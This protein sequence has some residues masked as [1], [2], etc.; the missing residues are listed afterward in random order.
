MKQ[1]LLP[2]AL[3]ACAACAST[4]EA[5]EPQALES[6]RSEVVQEPEPIG[7]L[8]ADLNAAQRAWTRLAMAA[9]TEEERREARLLEIDLMRRTQERLDEL[10]AELEGGPP[11]NRVIAASAVGFTRAPRAQPPLLAALE[12]P[13]PAVRSNAL[14][15]LTLLG[16]EDTPL[17]PICRLLRS[18]ED[19]WLRSNAALCL[20]TLVA[21]GAREDCA[22][23]AAR[24]GLLDPEP[25]VRAQSA[26]C[27]ATLLD[28]SSTRAIVDLL[29]DSVPLVQHA[30][31]R[32]LAHLGRE[33]ASERPL[34][35]KALVASYQDARGSARERLLTELQEL[36]GHHFG[37]EPDE[38]QDW[39]RRLQ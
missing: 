25:G 11:A 37:D 14:I 24:D 8:L 33:L 26:L 18:G 10:L 4:R 34:A 15:G 31:A 7:K 3:L 27:L 19:G 35:A 22:L 39:A 12:D 13:D 23:E 28:A 20:S 16:R 17:E 9:R 1:R 5:S 32:A 36:S 30:A 38:W 6:T 29:A 2:V 21:A